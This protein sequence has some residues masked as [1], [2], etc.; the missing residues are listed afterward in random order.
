MTERDPR[1]DA[2]VDDLTPVRRAGDVA[3]RF[4]GWLALSL[5]CVFALTAATGPFRPGAF[6]DLAHARFGL[7]AGLAFAAVAFGGL[8]ALSF[9]IPGLASRR[10]RGGVACVAGLLARRR[11]RC[12]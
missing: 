1:I 2:L 4:A 12:Y 11:P 8:A 3:T 5:V 7:E 10:L 6:A 9:G